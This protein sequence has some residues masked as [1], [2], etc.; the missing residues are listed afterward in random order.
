MRGT[1][2][3][4]ISGVLLCGLT[5]LA[6]AQAPSASAS[7]SDTPLAQ[8]QASYLADRL[9]GRPTASGEKYDKHALTAAHP[10]LPFGTEVLVRSLKT[11]KEVVVRII[12]RGPYLKD[13]VIDLSR[14]AAA[15]LG[16]KSFGVS[17]VEIHEPPSE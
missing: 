9:H 8:G 5:S 17:E 14:A 10:T 7:S 6:L 3:K 13:R 15:A 1:L 16:I 12:D 4:G 2:W 11:G